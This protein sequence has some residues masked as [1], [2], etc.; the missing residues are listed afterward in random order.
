M[1]GE[2]GF[3]QRASLQTPLS[4]TFG[5]EI[6]RGIADNLSGLINQQIT[7]RHR[8][9]RKKIETIKQPHNESYFGRLLVSFFFNRLKGKPVKLL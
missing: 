2:M 7:N 8:R 5:S 9:P 3:M 4:F 6:S 1:A